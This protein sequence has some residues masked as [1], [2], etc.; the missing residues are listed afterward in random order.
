MWY[1]PSLLRQIKTVAYEDLLR[2]HEWPRGVY[3]F[4]DMERMTGAQ[5]SYATWL[6]ER[7]GER[8]DAFR[9]LNHPTRHLR[10]FDLLRLL[11]ERGVN[12]FNV[13]RLH[14]LDAISNFPVFLRY[15]NRHTGSLTPLLETRSQVEDRIA[16]LAAA[17]ERL[18]NVIAVE[19]V[20]TVDRR[21]TFRKYGA[22]RIG[23]SI[24]PRHMFAG[25]HWEVK[26]S[27]N[28]RPTRYRAEEY[29]YLRQNPHAAQ[30]MEIFE[31]AGLQ[32]G[33]I[34][35]GLKEGRIQVWEIND[36][37]QMNSGLNMFLTKGR[38]GRYFVSIRA[39]ERAFEQETEKLVPGPAVEI[40]ASSDHVW[41]A[42][43]AQ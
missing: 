42:L 36:N 39:I 8:P 25:A 10:R 4:T 38:V 28:N 5:R 35:Y 16:A 19:F 20:D 6:W 17:G 33:R 34:D 37:P 12:D 22:F 30:V 26:V 40:R 7:M 15:E 11:H 29:A 9:L 32:Y 2:A 1:R 31:T 24:A 18:D 14:E 13:Y 43:C 27:T 3:L 41:R 23:D 21:G